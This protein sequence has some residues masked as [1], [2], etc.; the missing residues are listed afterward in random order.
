MTTTMTRHAR[1]WQRLRAAAAARG[2]CGSCGAADLGASRFEYP[3][4]RVYRRCLSC[5]AEQDDAWGP[6]APSAQR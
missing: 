5:G 1:E 4:G 6:P 2:N 3:D